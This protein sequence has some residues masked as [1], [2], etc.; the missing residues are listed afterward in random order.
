MGL[1]KCIAVCPS[2]IAVALSALNAN[3]VITGNSGSRTIPVSEFYSTMTNDLKP[4]EFITEI[5][6]PDIE[7]DNRQSFIKYTLREPVDFAIVSVACIKQFNKDT[8]STA[9]IYLGAIAAKPFRAAIAEEEIKGK[10][11]NEKLAQ[12]AADAQLENVKV[13]G[14]SAYKLEITRSLLKQAILH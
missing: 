6:I 7:G 2:D 12:Q 8:V 10:N 13:K 4:G 9:S 3:L 14:Q 11:I 5:K 1:D